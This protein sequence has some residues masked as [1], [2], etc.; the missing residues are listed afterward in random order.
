MGRLAALASMSIPVEGIFSIFIVDRR[1]KLFDQAPETGFST[2][3]FFES[4]QEGVMG[5]EFE[6]I[7]NFSR[8][9]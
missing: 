2:M 5:F 4:V 3:L 9:A 6:V 7:F 8:K 1:C